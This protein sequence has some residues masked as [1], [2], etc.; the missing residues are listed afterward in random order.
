MYG[1][2][3]RRDEIMGLTGEHKV[4][5]NGSE[6]GTLTVERNGLMTVFECE[7]DIVCDDVVRLAAARGDECVPIGVMMPV[8]GKLKLRKSFSKA[9]LSDLGIGGDDG[10][11]LIR[12]TED[13][14]IPKSAA[15]TPDAAAEDDAPAHVDAPQDACDAEDT[16]SY[17][18]DVPSMFCDPDVAEACRD[19]VGA[20]TRRRGEYRL[21]AVP[22]SGS[23]PFPMMP[24]FCF[25]SA[26]RIAG[27]DYIV[28]RVRN[29]KLEM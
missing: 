18:E 24:V 21:L 3:L 2:F 13:L 11:Y 28:F 27:G 5:F 1:I 26:E 17:A 4:L 19:V 15:E 23:E 22:V 6:A 20:L 12:K 14:C 10:F 25:G 7:C 8:G 16:W 29:G 9:A